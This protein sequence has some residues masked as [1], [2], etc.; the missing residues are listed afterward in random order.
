MKLRRATPAAPLP[1]G[2]VLSAS[3][4]TVGYGKVAVVR[5]LSLTVRAGEVLALVGPNGA[6][7]STTLLG[8]SGALKPSTGT[9]CIAGAARVNLDLRRMAQAGV[10]FIPENR[11]L[12]RGLSVASNI[13]LSGREVDA[14][15]SVFPVLDTLLTRQV[16]FLSG[17]E[18]QMLC[19]AQAIA[20]RPKVIMVDELSF[21]LAPPIVDR[22]LSVLREV[23]D[24]GVAVMVVEQA[25]S[26]VIRV[27]DR[28]VVLERGSIRLD[29][30][31]DEIDSRMQEIEAVYLGPR[32][33]DSP[34]LPLT[35]PE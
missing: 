17:G 30:G 9:V 20:A 13:R 29:I 21:G 16:G 25:L 15:V 18:Q 31:V 1:D 22:L 19:L 34:A 6:G 3:D 8:L 5:N 11:G 27:A 7:K 2:C 35:D 4:L 32:D 23:A 12:I 10:A 33:A 24:Q 28:V 26:H 14:V